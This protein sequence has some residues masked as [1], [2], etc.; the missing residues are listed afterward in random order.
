MKNNETKNYLQRMLQDFQTK[1]PN[2]KLH[3]AMMAFLLFS[4]LTV[5]D[6]WYE[7]KHI[8]DSI[9]MSLVGLILGCL[10]VSGYERSKKE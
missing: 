9:Y 7:D 4:I 5:V 1:E 10:G 8:N 3:I 2:S 6:L